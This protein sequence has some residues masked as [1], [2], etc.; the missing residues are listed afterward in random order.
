[1]LYLTAFPTCLRRRNRV[2][3]P[4]VELAVG[5]TGDPAA[6]EPHSLADEGI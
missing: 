1:V 5:I 3:G 6:E 2:L 4:N